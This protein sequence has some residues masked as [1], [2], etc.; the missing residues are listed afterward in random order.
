[1]KCKIIFERDPKTLK[2][3]DK[4]KAVKAPNGKRS[5]L[6]DSIKDD[7]KDDN[8]ALVNY[9][10]VYTNEFKELFGDWENTNKFKIDDE[11]EIHRI[12]TKEE[13]DSIDITPT[14]KGN[15]SEAKELNESETYYQRNINPRSGVGNQYSHFD[16]TF[17]TLFNKLKEINDVV[18]YGYKE[19]G[20]KS[21]LMIWM[22][23][24]EKGSK[25]L[26][27][28]KNNRDKL[29]KLIILSNDVNFTNP[30]TYIKKFGRDALE[31]R[32]QEYNSIP[33]N[34]NR[35]LR[36]ESIELNENKE[37]FIDEIAIPGLYSEVILN[38]RSKLSKY[39]DDDTINN[40]LEF[41]IK[42][43]YQLQSKENLDIGKMLIKG[44]IED[45]G[46]NNKLDKNGEPKYSE[47][48]DI[49]SPTGVEFDDDL[50]TKLKDLFKELYPEIK[51]E[52]T[53]EVITPDNNSLY[54]HDTV[55][56]KPLTFDEI[57][58]ISN[59]IVKL[60]SVSE[61]DYKPRTNT[62]EI[63]TKNPIYNER[64]RDIID[65]VFKTSPDN[66]SKLNINVKLVAKVL[67]FKGKDLSVRFNKDRIEFVN[68]KGNVI[69]V[70]KNLSKVQK[71][72]VQ[73]YLENNDDSVDSFIKGYFDFVQNKYE[74]Y[75][76]KASSEINWFDR[77]IEIKT[78]DSE[79]VDKQYPPFIYKNKKGNLFTFGV[80]KILDLES[81]E[82][83]S[84]ERVLLTDNS[85]FY[86]GNND[87]IISAGIM[88]GS[89]V[90]GAIAHTF[91]INDGKG[92]LSN[93]ER[94]ELKENLRKLHIKKRK[95]ERTVKKFQ[96]QYDKLPASRKVPAN[97]KY[98]KS[99]QGVVNEEI[100]QINDEI[101][102]NIGKGQSVAG[103][104]WYVKVDFDDKRFLYEFQTDVLND[105][106][107]NLKESNDFS[108]E[109][110]INKYKY[111]AI[112]KI[113][114][115]HF[116]KL[117]VKEPWR[118]ETFD[119]LSDIK[120]S[121]ERDGMIEHL[122]SKLISNDF[123]P[124]RDQRIVY[125]FI[126]KLNPSS[127]SELENILNSY[128]DEVRDIILSYF[129]K[130][131]KYIETGDM[132]RVGSLKQFIGYNKTVYFNKYVKPK[133]NQKTIFGIKAQNSS[134]KAQLLIN[135]IENVPNI[136]DRVYD[137][138]EKEYKRVED[139]VD[140]QIKSIPKNEFSKRD[141][142][143]ARLYKKMFGTLIEQGIQQA[144]KDGFDTIYLPTAESI[145][146][147][148]ALGSS[149]DPSILYATPKELNKEYTYKDVRTDKEES[150][151]YTSVGP[152]YS[153][154][155][156]IKNI[157]ISYETPKNSK[158]ELIKVDISNY[159]TEGINMFQ[160]E[161]GSIIGKANIEAGTVLINALKQKQ[162]TLPHEYAH[163]YIAWF[164][165]TPIVQ[166]GIK[167]WGS[168][169]ALV[170]AIG[171][172]V[173][174]QK[175]EAYNWW[176]RFVKFI[177]DKVGGLSGLKKEQLRNVLTDAFLTR[178]DLNTKLKE[179]DK[180]SGVSLKSKLPDDTI[181]FKTSKGSKYTFKDGKTS[182]EKVSVTGGTHKFGEV[183]QTVFMTNDVF[184]KLLS[185]I[186]SQKLEFD[187][188]DNTLSVTQESFS[189][190][191]STN[192]YPI[193]NTP[194]VN[195]HPLELIFKI[196]DSNTDQLKNT[197]IINPKGISMNPN[198]VSFHPGNA[199]TSIESSKSKLPDDTGDIDNTVKEK[200]FSDG[201]TQSHT[202]IL[203]RII[204]DKHPLAPLAEKLLSLSS[205]DM[206]VELV[207]K[208]YIETD[209]YKSGLKGEKSSKSAATYQ[210][211]GEGDTKRRV[212]NIASR[213]PIN[214]KDLVP[215]ILHE[216]LHGY[217]IS[218]LNKNTKV[219]KQ[220][221][222]IHKEALKYRDEFRDDY[223]LTSLNE[224]IVA[225][226]TNPYFIQDLQKLPSLGPN[227]SLWEDLL[228][229]FKAMF[230]FNLNE[231]TLFD[232]AF[233]VSNKV[234]ENY[235]DSVKERST[236]KHKDPSNE[237][238]EKVYNVEI[239]EET[240]GSKVKEDFKIS[241]DK[242]WSYK[243]DI[244]NKFEADVETIVNGM[245]N[246]SIADDEDYDIALE[247]KIAEENDIKYIT[248][249]ENFPLNEKG[250]VNNYIFYNK[251]GE[252]Q[253]KAIYNIR[254]LKNNKNERTK[255]AI[256]G[257][258]L[259]FNINEVSSFTG[260]SKARIKQ[261]IGVQEEQ[262]SSEDKQDVAKPTSKVTP[263]EIDTFMEVL[264]TTRD[265]EGILS[266]EEYLSRFSSFATFKDIAVAGAKAQKE[267]GILQ[268]GELFNFIAKQGKGDTFKV[269]NGGKKG[270]DGNFMPI[271]VEEFMSEFE[272]S[273]E[274]AIELKRLV[275]RDRVLIPMFQ[276]A[277]DK[278]YPLTLKLG[279]EVVKD[280]KERLTNTV[281]KEKADIVWDKIAIPKDKIEGRG[282]RFASQFGYKY[283]ELEDIEAAKEIVVENSIK[284]QAISTTDKIIFGHPGIGKSYVYNKDNTIIDFDERYKPEVKQFINNELSKL[285]KQINKQS[286]RDYKKANPKAYQDKL[287]EL[288]KRAKKDAIK[289]NKLLFASDMELLRSFS[290]D[291]DKVLT[292]SKDLF[293]ERSKQ[294]KDF[295]PTNT[296]LWKD[297]L[298]SLIKE[299]V[300]PNKLIITDK[301]LSD[302]IS[303]N[304]EKQGI[305]TII[306]T[307][308][309]PT[310]PIKKSAKKTTISDS[311]IEDKF[312]LRN[313]DG[314]RK[315]YIDYNKALDKTRKLNKANRDRPFKFTIIK[316]LGEKGDPSRTYYAIKVVPRGGDAKYSLSG[317]YA[318]Q[319][320]TD[321]E[322]N[323][324]QST[325]KSGVGIPVDVF[326]NAKDKNGKD[327]YSEDQI[328]V[329]ETYNN[330]TSLL[331]GK[332][333]E[334]N[335]EELPFILR[336]TFK[337]KGIKTTMLYGANNKKGYII[338]R[339]S[340]AQDII[341]TKKQT[342][343][344]ATEQEHSAAST[345]ARNMGT[346][347]HSLNEAILKYI[348]ESNNPGFEFKDNLRSLDVNLWKEDAMKAF[349]ETD[350]YKS[351]LKKGNDIFL[352]KSYT[353]Q[354]VTTKSH[355]SDRMIDKLVESMLSLYHQ[356]SVTQDE[357]NRSINEGKEVDE[358]VKHK[359]LFMLEKPVLDP[360]GST[361]AS[362]DKSVAGTMDIFVVFSD[363]SASI[364]DHKFTNLRPEKR[365]FK[366]PS[367][368][369]RDKIYEIRRAQ[370]LST[371]RSKYNDFYYVLPDDAVSFMKQES[372]NA[373]IG[374]YSQMVTSLY[375]VK[376]IRQARILP[377]ATTYTR[378]KTGEKRKNKK[379][380]EFE[381]TALDPET[382]KVE[383]ILTGQEDE[384]IAQWALDIEKTGDVKLDE[385]IKKL[386]D[387]KKAL[388][389]ERVEKKAWNDPKYIDRIKKL[390]ESIQALL[391]NRKLTKI[392]DSINSL[393][394]QI[395]NDLQSDDIT[396]E[397]IITH[398][399]D[400]KTFESFTK[401]TGVT[402]KNLEEK[403][404]DEIEAGEDNEYTTFSNNLMRARYKLNKNEGLLQNKL[405]S[406]VYDVNREG[407]YMSEK[408]FA[409]LETQMDM[410]SRGGA[411]ASWFTHL[412]N[413]NHPL[414]SLFSQV[415]DKVDTNVIKERRELESKVN[416]VTKELAKWG[417]SKGLS[418][419]KIYKDILTENDKLIF[420]YTNYKK[421]IFP[422]YSDPKNKSNNIK[423]FNENFE[424]VGV[425][426]DIFK[427]RLKRFKEYF[428]STSIDE[429][430]KVN[431]KLAEEKLNEWRNKNDVK[432][433]KGNNDAWTN[434]YVQGLLTPKNPE[435]YYT[436]EYKNLLRSENKP[437]LDFY[438]MYTEQM[439][440]LAVKADFKIGENFIPEIRKDMIDT[441]VQ[442]GYIT[443]LKQQGK[444]L[445]N[446]IKVVDADD[447][448]QQVQTDGYLGSRKVP[449]FF[450]H[451]VGKGNKSLDLSK[452]LMIF[453]DFVH[454]YKGHKDN[455]YAILA[456]RELLANTTGVKQTKGKFGLFKT[457]ARDEANNILKS[458]DNNAE[459]LKAFD[460]WIKFYIYGE[461]KQDS[462]AAANK[463]VDT[464]V[465]V[466]SY[467]SIALN[468]LSA[469]AGHVNAEAQLNY[470]AKKANYFSRESLGK[471][472]KDQKRFKALLE[473]FRKSTKD[474][475]KVESKML[476]A[477][478]FFEMAQESLTYEKANSVS[479]STMRST[480]KKDF[481]Y[482]M[483]RWSDDVID[484]TT[485][486]A[487]MRDYAI[488]P[489]TGHTQP[490]YKLKEFY[491]NHP[492]Y[493]NTEWKSLWDSIIMHKKDLPDSLTS[494]QRD[495]FDKFKGP[496]IINQHT[497][498]I[499]GDRTFT[500]FR[501]KA[502]EVVSRAKGN[503]SNA[504]TAL[505]KTYAVGR[506][507]M[508]YRG[509][510]PST[511]LERVKSEQYNLTME[512]FE[513]GRWV[514]AQ[515]MLLRRV[516]S[517]WK[518]FLIQ[519]IPFVEGDFS[520]NTS[521]DILDEMTPMQI[522]YR[523]FIADNPH[524]E[525]DKDNPSIDQVSYEEYYNTYVGE[526]K[527]LAKEIQTYFAIAGVGM[528]FLMAGGDDEYKENPL[529]RG[530][531][532]LIDRILLELGFFLPAPYV[533][534][535]ET[536]QLVTRKPAA[537]VDVI[538]STG[539]T[540]TNTFT[541]LFDFISGVESDEKRVLDLT[542]P[543]ELEWVTKKD[544][545]SKGYYFH[546]WVPP[547]KLG[548]KLFGFYDDS[549]ARETWWDYVTGEDFVK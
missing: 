98:L 397:Q 183:D 230:E 330:K 399:R 30:E 276:D 358:R 479:A 349:K 178:E 115:K 325:T 44:I 510:I 148:E 396:F 190:Y 500:D 437:L 236:I 313:T 9:Y 225:V 457:A 516:D 262:L 126:N 485:L 87:Q 361:D 293:F 192:K 184:L 95:L 279:E 224:F 260:V 129:S 218:E 456:M 189:G 434:I 109:H 99:K 520:E 74:Y 296:K 270:A 50:N 177:L 89:P 404:K 161:N 450:T 237:F 493:K 527:I 17:E 114:A 14:K 425:K 363:G 271:I 501:R 540:I 233:Y 134:K 523:Q 486:G 324:S 96:D 41:I 331:T 367:K 334:V 429:N 269:W 206:T 290:N 7:I 469:S 116:T 175:G 362:G 204:D 285:N 478:M 389:A 340:H 343:E 3:T 25:L 150:N 241:I 27:K 335:V 505:Y 273:K 303:K 388:H 207:D 13:Y 496:V 18:A 19:E 299:K 476:F 198:G 112:N 106:N 346:D 468:M 155:S 345:L 247:L 424:R 344:K 199:I 132:G 318:G 521:T 256:L 284:G 81:I 431:K 261:L 402:L 36:K 1:M 337:K 418:G 487:M 407:G 143:N 314:S 304:I 317:Q 342:E 100:A 327:L 470:L 300:D 170:Q 359:P 186:S 295:H 528:L 515:K 308:K 246:V 167:K 430:G 104:A 482:F 495:K 506:L 542:G 291:F 533:G 416:K 292:M 519:V 229:Y 426:D 357:I 441:I 8:E 548:D 267:H 60:D 83:G 350:E 371:K 26:E 93:E 311:T 328:K 40:I 228:K 374:R 113:V 378:E 54:Q 400:I 24:H 498:E 128:S 274:D 232:D 466:S 483:Q 458:K 403:Y 215:V 287:A 88:G 32:K 97:L 222:K 79:G 380:E 387:T 135:A 526:L 159:S 185:D 10:R 122:Q 162:D 383:F 62:I 16:K 494:E 393:A 329:I 120:K 326:K 301:Y 518:Q 449:I 364:Y 48:K 448:F 513:V 249:K 21:D 384:G 423:W 420:K 549:D 42:D 365:E 72:N 4:I 158:V 408:L 193:T 255:E 84:S 248:Y 432:Y 532:E 298:D 277:N 103:L 464:M 110:Y 503:M 149:G 77:E 421:E 534:L 146:I 391:I 201:N 455:E 319:P 436:E 2:V 539:K 208:P 353:S 294:R 67:P 166:E 101:T 39:T 512:Q 86:N 499:M 428:D 537:S 180:D 411:L 252:N 321:T 105:L 181:I 320:K 406:M 169:E 265:K 502:K 22:N 368:T 488:D 544:K 341:K 268:A 12:I 381:V 196:D 107:K 351:L 492:K 68:K 415:L 338:G 119:P 239:T 507:L 174:K 514:A 251:N 348:T 111:T 53:N 71:E 176:N 94:I 461:K 221:S 297:D 264:K 307:K 147:A 490:I 443:G 412:R 382:S 157:S 546:Q 47:I 386:I 219:A 213:A 187:I 144:K 395:E 475:E 23:Q 306:K 465:K 508:Q 45:S 394:V 37:L 390:D 164:R 547:L 409:S 242:T 336:E 117:G 481:A 145:R 438:N 188:T 525:P 63:E 210:E 179:T 460:K 234:L 405:T 20:V 398:L 529:M 250:H 454:K 422:D 195:L 375:G 352:N 139:Y 442:D 439:N 339:V 372:W 322:S 59:Y 70:V 80:D 427:A 66:I 6:F 52:Y 35:E 57:E 172:Q 85:L 182:R 473:S 524:L 15:N 355:D 504:D 76:V 433:N 446:A 65:D 92:P 223:P 463:V 235:S 227:K 288:W 200:Y 163:H 312:N 347:M 240:V 245:R 535:G 28:I 205:E 49:I 136:L 153:S 538:T 69:S 509:W 253:A 491:K 435:E 477:A 165:N 545:T 127:A 131:K 289:E 536:M 417:K 254:N 56:S 414:I 445:K 130:I 55:E 75:I 203:Q 517:K 61:R 453:S 333:V 197:N 133:V 310:P 118:G 379:G 137:S 202:T 123:D 214:T 511:V 168:E 356:V 275:E 413:S 82:S 315:R 543:F 370:G 366:K 272:I 151:S 480:M 216:M 78:K 29:R 484:N 266:N 33:P 282:F 102:A 209:E 171:E 141:K 471:S 281:G 194:A 497:G 212:I 211:F 73:E 459:M 354:G 474:T 156:K 309:L 90:K 283:G 152:F 462:S 125:N 231:R 160:K 244:V 142:I 140:S 258:L 43:P 369:Q 531:L 58:D 64:R 191:K 11:L 138:I 278:L 332:M 401:L 385:F 376:K 124:S 108:K 173:V 451:S 373:Q 419:V 31:L 220:L 472:R 444:N 360:A 154:L 522:K 34:L 323:A 410:G 541:E 392:A 452:S 447:G 238:F 377:V 121:L 305:T 489:T 226:Y 51:L 5:L 243:K 302:L 259:Q 46:I 280:F 217:T 316:I 91:Y 440:K 263:A 467:K 257:Y 530:L 286:R 38:L